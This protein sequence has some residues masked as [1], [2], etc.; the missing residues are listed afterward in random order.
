MYVNV[1]TSIAVG[2]VGESGKRE[3]LGFVVF[4]MGSSGQEEF[5]LADNIREEIV[6]IKDEP[7]LGFCSLSPKDNLQFGREAL[8]YDAADRRLTRFFSQHE[9]LK[10]VGAA[11]AF[12]VDEAYKLTVTTKGRLAAVTLMP[13]K[14]VDLMGVTS[15]PPNFS[16][17]I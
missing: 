2:Q 11:V 12:K 15:I 13:V 16:V 6:D 14:T 4:G 8:E 17:K 1:D 10:K 9:L 7:K 3:K 5:Q